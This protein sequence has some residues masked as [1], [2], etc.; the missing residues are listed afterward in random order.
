M[1]KN[2]K[3]LLLIVLSLAIFKT[4][5]QTVATTEGPVKIYH[6]EGLIKV[7]N[8]PYA[9]P[10]VKELRWKAP[11]SPLKRTEVWDGKGRNTVCAQVRNQVLFAPEPFGAVTGSEDCLYL[12][13]VAPEN[14]AKTHPVIVWIHGGSNK[15]GSKSDEAYDAE[16]LA[17]NTGAV[18]VKVNYRL[19]ILGGLFLPDMYGDD[20]ETTT[21]NY[22]LLDL[23]QSLKWIRSNIASFGGDA[24]N[25]TL[26]GES[27]GCIDI[28]GLL[29]SPLSH[30][31]YHKVICSSGFPLIISKR[32]ARRESKAALMKVLIKTG[33]V[34]REKEAR[35]F[36]ENVSSKELRQLLYNLD[37]E[38]LVKTSESFTPAL[39]DDGHVL[40]KHGLF[41]VNKS[42]TASVPMIVGTTQNEASYFLVSKG[43]GMSYNELW[44]AI[45]EGNNID[46]VER[47]VESEDYS[48]YW[49]KVES[50]T[51][52]LLALVNFHYKR[53]N[54]I[55][56]NMYKYQFDVTPN[57]SPWKEL[58]GSTHASDV[59][60]LFGK[61]KFRD[62]NFFVFLEP[63]DLD[64]FRAQV[65]GFH[66][67]MKS[68]IET[69]VPGNVN[70]TTWGNWNRK[71]ENILHVN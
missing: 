27:A 56:P 2:R 49:K 39:V 69:G 18:V 6:E 44:N 13:I 55:N 64:T 4:N 17:K 41:V 23:I 25:I 8:I 43:S 11:L 45:N 67:F 3:V 46:K 61:E 29:L 54:R 15:Y 42:H 26:M 52:K 1:Y 12:D 19:G 38:T 10:P 21:G 35:Q 20:S 7:Y 68:F 14:R 65:N 47:F 36:L 22:L 48:D 50:T 62:E 40:K 58:L 30:G 34:T 9:Q 53:Y 28:W 16:V 70:G 71:P 59:I 31:L 5:A 24:S 33:K 37:A 63:S 57:N 60:Y 66:S 51:K 32:K